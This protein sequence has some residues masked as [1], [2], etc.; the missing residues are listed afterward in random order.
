MT[1]SPHL[2]VMDKNAHWVFLQFNRKSAESPAE[3]ALQKPKQ[4]E[5]SLTDIY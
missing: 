5:N 3:A 1:A 2:V 4:H